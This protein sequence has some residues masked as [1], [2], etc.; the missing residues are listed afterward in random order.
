MGIYFWPR[1][2]GRGDKVNVEWIG[3]LLLLP[4]VQ[5]KSSLTS[6]KKPAGGGQSIFLGLFG[7]LGYMKES[8]R[9]TED[10]RGENVSFKPV[11]LTG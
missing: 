6:E 4:A 5:A 7:K 8:Q 11:F 2:R 3:V 1:Y 9:I 10:V